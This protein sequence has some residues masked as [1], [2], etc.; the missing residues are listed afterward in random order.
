MD[1]QRFL[2]RPYEDDGYSDYLYE[3]LE[4]WCEDYALIEGDS[5]E[6]KNAIFCDEK[7]VFRI[8]SYYLDDEKDLVVETEEVEEIDILRELV[9]KAYV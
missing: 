2:E 9:I 3:E 4:K 8:T 6:D 5:Y 7:S 1:H